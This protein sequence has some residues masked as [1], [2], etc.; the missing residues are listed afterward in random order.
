MRNRR[1]F[2]ICDLEEA[3]VVHLADYLNEQGKMPYEVLAFTSLE[4][5]IDYAKGNPIEVLLISAEAMTDEVRSLDIRRTIILSDGEAP[6]LK[7]EQ[8]QI[9]KYQDSDSIARQVL[10]CTGEKEQGML[11]E[12]CR[13]LGVY[14][15]VG[16][17]GKTLFSLTLAQEIG[18]EEKTL[19][20]NM[21]DYSGFEALMRTTF[22][23][24][25]TDMVFLAEQEPESFSARLA[26]TIQTVGNFDFIPPAFF[27]EDIRAVGTAQWTAFLS[28]LARSGG[29][30]TIVLDIGSNVEDL[31]GLLK[32]CSRIYMP[33]LPD[34]VSRAKVMQFE[35]DMEALSMEQ[36]TAEMIRLYL[37][38]TDVR[39]AGAGLIDDQAYGRMGQFVR[40]LM[41]QEDTESE[42][43]PEKSGEEHGIK[44][45]RRRGRS[46]AARPGEGQWEAA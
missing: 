40:R 7:G 37:P 20:L 2:A 6:N 39:S 16:R 31:A 11:Q 42:E 24:D 34:P 44:R 17:C 33:I 32:L 15:P 45:T 4:R 25:L 8:P 1:I 23:C 28:Q 13:I 14:S 36:L 18:E 9:G 43:I 30:R 10:T 38:V 22:Q 46:A 27:P 19:Y 21:E 35:R 3:Y 41:E 12:D 26:D 5:L 29:Y